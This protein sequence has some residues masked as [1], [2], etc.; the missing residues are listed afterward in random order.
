ME[1]AAGNIIP[2]QA[3]IRESQKTSRGVHLNDLTTNLVAQHQK[4]KLSMKA[5]DK[6]TTAHALIFSGLNHEARIMQPASARLHNDHHVVVNK[7]STLTQ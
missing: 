3:T 5:R 1:V 4:A 7:T 6:R 2:T